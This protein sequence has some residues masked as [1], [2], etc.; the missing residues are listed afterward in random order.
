M[1]CSPLGATLIAKLDELS[2][3]PQHLEIPGV[4]AVL[5]HFSEWSPADAAINFDPLHLV[6]QPIKS[7]PAAARCA[8]SHPAYWAGG[9][10]GAPKPR[11]L[12]AR[13]TPGLQPSPRGGATQTSKNLVNDP[14]VS[15]AGAKGQ[16]D[17]D[18]LQVLIQQPDRVFLPDH[19][20]Q[21][22]AHVS[23]WKRNEVR[24]EVRRGCSRRWH[25]ALLHPDQ[26]ALVVCPRR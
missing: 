3:V 25:S 21:Q 19:T 24:P 2:V 17:Q 6:S 9:C 26:N 7:H 23:F 8:G 12:R 10:R 11:L 22:V 5:D 4:V 20:P 1:W 16:L 13:R 14:P 15:R 18:L